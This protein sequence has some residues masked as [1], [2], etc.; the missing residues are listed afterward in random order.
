MLRIEPCSLNEANFL[1]SILHRHHKPVVGHRFSLACYDDEHV[2][3]AVICGRP[4]ARKSDQRF[5]LEITRCVSTG[6]PNVISKLMG[7]VVKIARLSGY[8]RVQTYTLPE[9]GGASMRA[10]GFTFEGEKG[11]GDWNVPSR[12]GRRVDQPQQIKWRWAK[13]LTN[14]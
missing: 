1:V 5:T 2:V 9:E 4:V 14:A 13:D 6:A 3:G 12:N 11:G 8:R 7:V 10:S